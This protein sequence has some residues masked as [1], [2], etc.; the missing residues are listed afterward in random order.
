MSGFCE[1]HPE[2]CPKYYEVEEEFRSFGNTI[3]RRPRQHKAPPPEPTLNIEAPRRDITEITTR[4]RR[5]I[6]EIKPPPRRRPPML[7]EAD[8]GSEMAMRPRRDITEMTVSKHKDFGNYD[9]QNVDVPTRAGVKKVSRKIQKGREKI[10]KNIE[11]G[12]QTVE[13]SPEEFKNAVLAQASYENAYKSTKRAEKYVKD[14]ANILPELADFEIIRDPQFTN[15]NHTAFR[16]ARTGEVYLSYRGSDGEFFDPEANI[17]SL[18]RGKGTRLK[19]AVDW[20]TNM[21]TLGGQEHKTTRYKNA[22]RT[23]EALAQSE[24]IPIHELNTTGHSLGA[25][26]SDHVS[27]VLG[28]KSVSF[29]PARNPFAKRPIHSQS[30]IKSFATWFDPVS[31]AR[32]AHARY[33]GGEPEHIE[34]KNYTATIGNESGMIDQHSLEKQFID[35]LELKGGK[36]ISERATPIRYASS[37]IGGATRSTLTKAVAGLGGAAEVAQLA[38]PFAITPKYETKGETAFRQTDDFL[39]GAKITM[40]MS[41]ALFKVNPMFALLDE[42]AMMATIMDFDPMLPPEAKKYLLKKIGLKVKDEPARYVAPPKAIQ[43]LQSKSRREADKELEARQKLADAYGITLNEAINLTPETDEGKPLSEGALERAEEAQE[44][45]AERVDRY[46]SENDDSGEWMRF[47]NPD[48]NPFPLGDNPYGIGSKESREYQRKSREWVREA[49]QDAKNEYAV[50]QAQIR[51]YER[52]QE[53]EREAEEEY[54]YQ[55][56]DQFAMD[57]KEADMEMATQDLKDNIKI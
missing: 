16:N 33:R 27:E 11:L 29:D 38:L 1:R 39:E 7:E 37:M 56:S 21:H 50:N 4:P 43:A 12:T 46:R 40:A 28:S 19:N 3:G 57:Q 35:P 22:V 17:D 10:L 15:N 42:P 34:H 41:N 9:Y 13:H 44:R 6:T 47:Y 51:R 8:F 32:N 52:E 36:I 49:E 18:M 48:N 25:G 26:Q 55:Q 24:G 5:D 53:L 23:A 45:F 31:L 54:K 30:R 2:L 14:K 20:G